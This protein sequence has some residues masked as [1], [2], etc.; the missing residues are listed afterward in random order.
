MFAVESLSDE[1]LEKMLAHP[2]FLDVAMKKVG[3]RIE[4]EHVSELFSL[5]PVISL[6]LL[7]N[8]DEGC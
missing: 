7:G 5:I 6:S 4:Y 3:S 8:N 1:L 2:K